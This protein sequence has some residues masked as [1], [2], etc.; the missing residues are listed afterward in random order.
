MCN[1]RVVFRVGMRN[2]IDAPFTIHPC[3]ANTMSVMRPLLSVLG[4]SLL[5]GCAP[6]PVAPEAS[7][8][9]EA[10]EPAAVADQ[11]RPDAREAGREAVEAAR[12]AAAKAGEAAKKLGEAG[13]AAA[14]AVVESTE[15]KLRKGAEAAAGTEPM[16]RDAKEAA[17]QAAQ[18]I[19]DATRD[20]AQRL[21]EAGKGA[22]D[23]VRQ[24]SGTAADGEDSDVD[25]V[26]EQQPAP[27]EERDVARPVES[28]APR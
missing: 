4:M 14:Q 5:L 27:V 23:S 22:I 7:K 3:P 16:V 26:T 21:K 11:S 8:A 15:D 17:E 12:E 24:R 9:P 2:L 20:A 18:R 13:A 19:A 1:L 28:E 10:V 25:A 6:E